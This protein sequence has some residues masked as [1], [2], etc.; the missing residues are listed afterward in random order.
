MQ[1]PPTGDPNAVNANRGPALPPLHMNGSR[2]GQ[3]LLT[4]ITELSDRTRE[5]TV[6]GHFSPTEGELPRAISGRSATANSSPSLTAAIQQ[7]TQG[8]PQVGGMAPASAVVPI[9]PAPPLRPSQAF[10]PLPPIPGSNLNTPPFTPGESA[11]PPN[12]PGKGTTPAPAPAPAPAPVSAPAPAP[13]PVAVPAAVVGPPVARE[14]PTPKSPEDPLSP[15]SFARSLWTE[16]PTS[17]L[18]QPAAAPGITGRT[19][20]T[21]PEPIVPRQVPTPQ[22]RPEQPVR[23]VSPVSLERPPSLSNVPRSQS[24]L[25]NSISSTGQQVSASS[26]R[27]TSPLATSPYATSPTA[28]SPFATSPTASSLA[29]PSR[30]SASTAPYR[31]DGPPQYA[32]PSHF[33]PEKKPQPQ[34]DTAPLSPTISHHS[35]PAGAEMQSPDLIEPQPKPSRSSHAVLDAPF[36]VGDRYLIVDKPIAHYL[37][38]TDPNSRARPKLSPQ[39]ETE[40]LRLKRAP[41][42]TSFPRRRV[43]RTSPQSIGTPHNIALNLVLLRTSNKRTEMTSRPKQQRRPLY[44][45]RTWKYLNHMSHRRP[46]WLG[47]VR[48]KFTCKENPVVPVPLR[49]KRSTPVFPV[50]TLVLFKKILHRHHPPHR[51]SNRPHR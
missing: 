4:P 17:P 1:G 34:V 15:R 24:P 36:M 26:P 35:Y 13:V 10:E 31:E 51:K 38:R 33:T 29:G 32:G 43:G 40:G 48:P 14:A 46:R 11:T 6:D 42:R 9:E 41:P 21:S 18:S 44:R 28:T 30:P 37:R 47:S 50:A 2:H 8:S 39:A 45:E 25:R 5:N 23:T 22:Q 27:V 20:T 7:V 12:V 16:S 3:G 49:P 19:N